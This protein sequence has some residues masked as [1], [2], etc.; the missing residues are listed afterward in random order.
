MEPSLKTTSIRPCILALGVKAKYESWCW[1]NLLL[2][3][4]CPAPPLCLTFLTCKIGLAALL[5][6]I[7]LYSDGPQ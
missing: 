6:A 3:F 2:G 5:V 1:D 4:A 7:F